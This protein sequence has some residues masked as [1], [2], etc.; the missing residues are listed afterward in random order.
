M[1]KNAD[2]GFESERA[3]E[4]SNFVGVGGKEGEDFGLVLELIMRILIARDLH[5]Q[6]NWSTIAWLK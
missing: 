3:D 6:G 2:A 1:K 5:C 4:R